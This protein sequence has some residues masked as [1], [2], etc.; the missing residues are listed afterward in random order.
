LNR[1]DVEVKSHRRTMTELEKQL[2]EA[3]DVCILLVDD[4]D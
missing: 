4:D 1:K 2:N 3:R